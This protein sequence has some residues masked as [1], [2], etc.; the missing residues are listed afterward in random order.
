[1][2]LTFYV[3]SSDPRKLDKSL[4][5]LGSIENVVLRSEQS[6][7]DP[8]FR[9]ATNS[10]PTAFNYCYCDRT[11]RYYFCEPPVLVR[12]GLFDIQC[13]TDTLS[14]FKDYIRAQTATVTR[15]QSRANGYLSD[16]RYKALAYEEIVTKQ[17]PNAMENDSLILLTVG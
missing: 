14:T 15:N 4:A 2:T 9:I 7:K 16:D 12:N 17:F 8:I 13:H 3:N 10:L 11:M 6:A 1:M 5:S